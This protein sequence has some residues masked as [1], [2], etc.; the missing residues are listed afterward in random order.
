[1]PSLSQQVKASRAE[2]RKLSE[3][4]TGGWRPSGQK[5]PIQLRPGEQC[6]AHGPAQLWQYLEGDG[7]YVHKT[8]F[9]FSALGVAM[10]AGT[11]VG[12]SVRKSRAAREAAARFRPVDEGT[13]YLTDMRLAMQ[14]KMQWYDIWFEDIRSVECNSTCITIQSAGNPPVQ[15]YVWPVDYYYVLYHFIAYHNII[16]VPAEVDA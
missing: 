9:G 4:L 7:T 15:L 14:G 13:L 8:R 16:E 11:V 10:A 6:Y 1:M 3:S 2:G 12:N 5:V